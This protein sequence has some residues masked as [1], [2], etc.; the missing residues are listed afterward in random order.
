LRVT[1]V[2][3]LASAVV[4]CSSPQESEP[5]RGHIFSGNAADFNTPVAITNVGGNAYVLANYSNVALFDKS[6]GIID[7]IEV[8]N[9]EL[10][11]TF[12]P[13]SFAV[14]YVHDKILIA[15][16][17]S[18]NVI[19][20]SLDKARLKIHFDRLI[21]DEQTVSPEGVAVSGD[22]AAV[23]NY[24]GDNV[25]FF[26]QSK[27]NSIAACT[28]SVREPHGV[29]F[30]GDFAYATS[31]QD[32]SLIK[33]DP[34]TCSITARVGEIG[35]KAKQFLWPTQVAV[36]DDESVA[37]SDAHTGLISVYSAKT[38]DF[39]KSFGGNGPGRN[40]LNMPYGL[41]VGG[42]YLFVTSAFS[43]KIMRFDKTSGR[44]LES[45]SARPGW[46]E[47]AD[48]SPYT[49]NHEDRSGYI[50]KHTTVT[51]DGAC[52]HPGYARLVSCNGGEN[53]AMP[54]LHG[55]EMYFIQVAHEGD[56]TLIFSPQCP[57][58]LLFGAGGWARKRE[59]TLGF[60]HWLIAG[61]VVGPNGA[62]HINAAPELR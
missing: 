59:I 49:L 30:L 33:I 34:K 58:A 54:P 57:I 44:P 15:N 47:V 22:L 38:L 51:L 14:D 29:V 43:D 18:N 1:F 12:V 21:G 35:W 24:D 60:D 56:Q 52:Y 3:A 40:E 11:K 2:I 28:I 31:L 25:Q 5:V 36:W 48:G 8:E 9:P 62:F 20:A 10:V 13:T 55:S 32:R 41:A 39:I 19:V 27:P 42:S 4:A 26:D 61:R 7:N 46:E 16:Y 37:V 23:A 17:T 45:W 50:D 53:V 6:T